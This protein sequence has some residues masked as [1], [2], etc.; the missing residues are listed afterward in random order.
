MLSDILKKIII[1]IAVIMA[2]GAIILVA[3]SSTS[4]KKKKKVDEF[5][6]EEMVIYSS[7][8][9]AKRKSR[10]TTEATTA[11]KSN[12]DFVGSEDEI[13]NGNLATI[14]NAELT[15]EQKDYTYRD[16][17]NETYPDEEAPVFLI[18]RTSVTVG[19]GNTFDIHDYIGYGDDV[20]RDVELSVTGDVDTSTNGTY[21]LTITL[22]DDAGHTTSSKMEV[23][24]ADSYDSDSSG[25]Q[26]G[27]ETFESFCENYKAD[28][29]I[30]GIDVSRWQENI[31]FQKVKAAGC[32]FV[33]MRMGG[34]DDGSQYTDKYYAENMAKAKA[35]GLKVGVY[36][37]AEEST[38]EQVRNNVKYIKELLGDEK[39]DFPVVYDWEDFESFENYHMNLHDL[40]NCFETFCQELEK[41]G[42]EACLYSSLNFLENTWTNENNHLVWLAHYTSQTSYTGEYFMWQHSSIGR[43]DGVNTAVDFN[44]LYTDKFKYLNN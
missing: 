6:T 11:M 17:D 33:I 38:P 12:T 7:G 22:K 24:V 13:E 27:S 8:T 43:I 1:V 29:A 4:S 37:H 36:W 18:N 40:N 9:D 28:N 42:Y 10:S 35:A 30:F 15:T 3:I 5:A 20:D 16:Y 14:S 23:T 2:V 32:D 31:D 34:F 41:L 26:K 39:L 44:V 19:R 21:Y 25:G